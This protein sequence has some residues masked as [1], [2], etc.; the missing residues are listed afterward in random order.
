MQ[1]EHRHSG[2]CDVFRQNSGY[3]TMQFTCCCD[4]VPYETASLKVIAAA[5]HDY[6]LGYVLPEFWFCFLSGDRNDRQSYRISTTSNAFCLKGILE[7][8]W[9]TTPS[10]RCCEYL[11]SEDIHPYEWPA[12]SFRE[13]TR[14]S[15]PTWRR[16]CS[17]QPA[18]AP[19]LRRALL[20]ECGSTD[21]LFYLRDLTS[22]KSIKI[23]SRGQKTV[24]GV[25]V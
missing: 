15:S 1:C 14:R 19:E 2:L 7:L 24:D 17:R 9:M 10:H 4:M 11:Q 13:P 20:L 21:L 18:P 22:S 16:G 8:L 5:L 6:G 23:I 3:G 25:E 12:F